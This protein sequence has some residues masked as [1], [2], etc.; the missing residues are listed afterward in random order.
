[1]SGIKQL[2]W[3]RHPKK[4]Q[5]YAVTGGKYVGQFFVYITQN[6]H[7]YVFLS[8]PDMEQVTVPC[9]K[10][11]FGIDNKILDPVSVLPKKVYLMC[12]AQYNQ[13]NS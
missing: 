8:L 9:D 4:R 10:F 3:P 2:L 12:E 5:V 7:D 13:L 11:R 1:M 6:E